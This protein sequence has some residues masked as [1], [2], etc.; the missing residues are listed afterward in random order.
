MMKANRA[1]KLQ[2]TAIA[3]GLIACACGSSQA[4][5]P[6]TVGGASS[7]SGGQSSAGSSNLGGVSSTGGSSSSTGGSSSTSASNPTGGVSSSGGVSGSGGTSS[8]TG[9]TAP[10]SGGSANTKVTGTGGAA[11]GGTT[12][13]SATGGTKN[14]TTTST[15]T[16]TTGGNAAGGTNA[17]GVGTG[18]TSGSNV[19]GGN[20]SSGGTSVNGGASSTGTCPVI[21]GFENAT[22]ETGKSPSEVGVRGANY[23]KNN[24]LQGGLDNYSGDGYAWTFGYVGSLQFTQ[25]TGDKTN[26]Q[27]MISKLNCST[28]TGPS[29]KVGKEEVDNRA[30]GDLP[31]EIFL[32]NG[33]TACKTL[34]MARA[35][36]QWKTTTS[37]G[38]TADARYWID[39]MYMITSLQVWAYRVTKDPVY[40]DRAGKTMI[41][42]IG[43]L[44]KDNDDK[45]HGLFWHTKNSHAYWA[46]ANGWVAAGATE[47]LLELPDSTNR[48]TIMN[49]YKAQMAQLIKLQFPS[50]AD[51][52]CWH[53]VLD[54]TTDTRS[55][56]ESSS[57]AMFTFALVTGLKNGWLSG[58]DYVT[59]ALNGWKCIANKT[60][61]TGLLTKVCEGTGEGTGDLASQQ[62]YYLSRATPTGDRHGQGP[63]LW[64]ATALLRK[65]C[66]GVR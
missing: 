31:L 58:D 7:G 17:G 48:T 52:G 60:D 40:L 6:A 50:G 45:T 22:Y 16:K 19:S 37:D 29:N 4:N 28:F 20:T 25:L 53:Q 8:P 63:L 51:Q 44:Q 65:D 39:D 24:Q 56:A 15:G 43:A 21:S 30:F 9:G 57:T 64:A 41:A 49:A 42:Y 1:I 26:N 46:R 66:P 32:E 55:Y 54:L 27:Q 12:A 34:G 3:V 13:A 18:G 23:F 10:S 35:D 11:T 14:T 61:S 33:D 36:N 38:I 62:S 59:A 2:C 5:Q 47:L